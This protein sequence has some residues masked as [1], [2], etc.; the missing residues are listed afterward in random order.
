VTAGCN[1]KENRA[2][3]I[4]ERG[5]SYIEVMCAMVVLL[6]GILGQLSALAWCVLRQREAEQQNVA[7]Q[8]ATSTMES[9][10]AARDL[11]DENG[12]SGWEK[13]N[14]S[15]V[16]EE[17]IFVSGWHAIREDSGKDGI[18]GTADDS[19]APGTTCQSGNYKNTSAAM[20]GFQRRII[21]TD[22]EE[23]GNPAKKRRLEIRI[24]FFVGQAQ[25]E[26][27]VATVIS[28]LPFYK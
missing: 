28:E 1:K 24:R 12:I 21:I 26:H 18:Q 3:N 15:D 8:I 14:N 16:H 6:I 4:G 20:D 27:T 10:F 2:K 9:I 17:G 13:I 23:S 25:R 11:G 19:C 5:F 7:R 22:I